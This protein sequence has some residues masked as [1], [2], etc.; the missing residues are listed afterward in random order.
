MWGDA[1]RV[2]DGH[3]TAEHSD[4]YVEAS[5]SVMQQFSEAAAPGRWLVDLVPIR[6]PKLLYLSRLFLDY[7][8]S[9]M[10]PSG[11]PERSFTN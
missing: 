8:Q 3:V 10:F 6:K 7:L 2:S 4:L 5:S 9:N 1:E 11:F